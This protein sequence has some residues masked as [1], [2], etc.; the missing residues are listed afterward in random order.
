LFF[1]LHIQFRNAQATM[2]LLY[3]IQVVYKPMTEIISII[4]ILGQ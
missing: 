1:P 4:K 3:Q 2:I